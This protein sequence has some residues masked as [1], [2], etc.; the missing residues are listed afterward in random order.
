MNLPA[1]TA[2]DAAQRLLEESLAF[3]L[4]PS[5]RRSEL[6][7]GTGAITSRDQQVQP[8][9]R[10]PALTVALA[11]LEAVAAAGVIDAEQAD[12]WRARFERALEIGQRPLPK[13]DP[14][15]AQRAEQ[16]VSEREASVHAHVRA[17]GGDALLKRRSQPRAR[18]AAFTA[19]RYKLA[20]LGL[21]SDG[22]AFGDE[23][24]QVMLLG[25][26][27]RRARLRAVALAPVQRRH[28]GLRVTCAELYED[29]VVV[30]WQRV[31]E[32]EPDEPQRQRDNQDL[33]WLLAEVERHVPAM[34]LSDDQ[35]TRYQPVGRVRGGGPHG[36]TPTPGPFV[37]WGA[38]TFAPA[39]PPAATRLHL[40]G[41]GPGLDLL[42]AEQ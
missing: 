40:S 3:L 21:I 19:A 29:A 18:W 42:V 8:S 22:R 11:R 26:E 33:G 35:D 1:E 37:I 27:P 34:E 12:A 16:W 24:E 25:Q 31:I 4:P 2:D 28:H 10:P 41:A 36:P 7:G 39:A 30:R 6:L 15:L 5:H 9:D 38:T 14:A 20:E 17:G 32:R 13:P 23:A